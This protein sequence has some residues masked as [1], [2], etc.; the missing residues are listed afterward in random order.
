[1]FDEFDDQDR[2]S[3]GGDIRKARFESRK[4]LVVHSK[5]QRPTIK[6]ESRCCKFDRLSPLR[7]PE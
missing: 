2:D 5:W 7:A 3:L 6:A 4:P 1:M